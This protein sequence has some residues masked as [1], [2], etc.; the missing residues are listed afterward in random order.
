MN[1]RDESNAS[2]ALPEDLLALAEEYLTLSRRWRG[3]GESL[4]MDEARRL[5][6]LMRRLEQA[7]A[8]ARGKEGK[9]SGEQRVAL[10]VPTWIEADYRDGSHTVEGGVIEVS[11]EGAFIRSA[12]PP[13]PGTRLRLQLR[14]DKGDDAID[15]VAEVVWVRN[16]PDDHGPAGM[17]VRFDGVST[18]RC[19]E[20]IELMGE[21]LVARLE[22]LTD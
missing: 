5:S 19:R 14:P 9:A 11:E 1:D 3:L 8:D 4:S 21:A 16:A 20:L 13:L 12:R 22:G 17:G 18:E 2:E 6:G 10:R 15:L 7:L